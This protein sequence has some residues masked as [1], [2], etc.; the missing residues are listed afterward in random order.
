M[1]EKKKKWAAIVLLIIIPL[2]AATINATLRYNERGP[3]GAVADF[4]RG[5]PIIIPMSLIY[6]FITEK[7]FRT[8]VITD[9]LIIIFWVAI[10]F[11]IGFLIWLFYNY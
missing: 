9:V 11:I 7:D 3:F 5:L 6:G 2:F 1:V 10:I 4:L 8:L